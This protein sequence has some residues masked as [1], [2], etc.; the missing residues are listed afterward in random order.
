VVQ[1]QVADNHHISGGA[2]QLTGQA[3]VVKPHTRVHLPMYLSTKVGRRK[4]WGKLVVR[5]S[6]LNM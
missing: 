4:S 6:R 2:A 1:R 5:I 3:V